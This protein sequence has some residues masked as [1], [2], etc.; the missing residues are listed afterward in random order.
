MLNVKTI[1]KKIQF[2]MKTSWSKPLLAL[3]TLS[4]N[5]HV[6]MLLT[7]QLRI[8]AHALEIATVI[9][10]QLECTVEH[11]YEVQD[12]DAALAGACTTNKAL[13]KLN[14]HTLAAERCD[15]LTSKITTAGDDESLGGL[16]WTYRGLVKSVITLPGDETVQRI[17]EIL[18]TIE[19]LMGGDSKR[20]YG[21][22]V[23]NAVKL[24]R[25]WVSETPLQGYM[26]YRFRRF[27]SKAVA[28]VENMHCTEESCAGMDIVP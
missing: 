6:V 5:K 26:A 28:Y 8:T 17:A 12:L 22:D 14:L 16:L 1:H 2:S 21:E 13:K 24:A 23:R 10:K 20:K 11:V 25:R 7:R 15:S 4:S 19:I 18:I 27:A 9:F 3:R